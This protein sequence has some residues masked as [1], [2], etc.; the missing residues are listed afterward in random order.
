M[1]TIFIFVLILA[2]FAVSA[3]KASISCFTYNASAATLTITEGHAVSSIYIKVP[4]AATDSVEIWG[5]DKV[6][7]AKIAG[8]ATLGPGEGVSIGDGKMV[9]KYLY[10]VIRANSKPMIITETQVGR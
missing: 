5:N 6:I 4:A 2:S 3:Q 1:K 8:R 10:L 9:I 7:G